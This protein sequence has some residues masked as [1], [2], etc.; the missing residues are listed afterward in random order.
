MFWKK[1]TQ[2]T[3]DLKHEIEVLKLELE[4]ERARREHANTKL[5]RTS[6]RLETVQ[7]ELDMMKLKGSTP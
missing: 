4:I 1:D 6:E 2:S 7:W 3:I 5:M